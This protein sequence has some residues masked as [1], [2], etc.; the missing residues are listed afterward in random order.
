[1]AESSITRAIE[2]AKTKAIKVEKIEMPKQSSKKKGDMGIPTLGYY[3]PSLYLDDKDL[4]TISDYSAGEKV[5]LV[6]ECTVKGVTLSD[7]IREGKPTKR[8]SAE[9]E[10]DSFADI[11]PPTKSKGGK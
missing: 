10:I 4:S 2:S 1:M 9:I 8:Y 7:S 11:T 6:V 5:V 3:K